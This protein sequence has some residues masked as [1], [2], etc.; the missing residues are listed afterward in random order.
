MERRG[1][2]SLNILKSLLPEAVLQTIVG[3]NEHNEFVVT[4]EYAKKVLC[5]L[6]ASDHVSGLIT[7]TALVTPSKKLEKL[8]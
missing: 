7:V 1:L 5:A 8:N 4:D 2:E 6:R 3:H